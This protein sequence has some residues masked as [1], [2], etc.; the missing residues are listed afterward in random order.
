MPSTVWDHTSR[1]SATRVPSWRLSCCKPAV[2]PAQERG[3]IWRPGIWY[4]SHSAPSLSRVT[5]CR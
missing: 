4:R 2:L 1:Q 5:G 3:H